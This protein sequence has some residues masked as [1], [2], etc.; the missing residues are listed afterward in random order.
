MVGKN[1]SKMTKEYKFDKKAV[2]KYLYKP[3]IITFSAHILTGLLITIIS[4]NTDLG[5]VF[6]V[7]ITIIVIWA[8]IFMLPLLI[9]YLNHRKLSKSTLFKVR[10]DG[11]FTFESA[12]NSMQFSSEEITKV[13][14]WLSPPSFDDRIDFLYFGKYHFTTIYTEKNE[15]INISCLVFDCTREV[16]TEKLINKERKIFPLM[17]TNNR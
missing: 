14:L 17:G 10:E 9:L 6:I 8:I 4:R 15:P 16:F 12:L 13:K 1:S 11:T 3:I 7:F 2:W 5:N